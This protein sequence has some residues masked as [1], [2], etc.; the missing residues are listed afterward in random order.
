MKVAQWLKVERSRQHGD[1]ISL[2]FS[3]RKESRIAG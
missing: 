2:L 3:L 1:F